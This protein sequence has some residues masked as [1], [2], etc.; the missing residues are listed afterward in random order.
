MEL[1]EPK[2]KRISKIVLDLNRVIMEQNM[3]KQPL[4]KKLAV[5][6]TVDDYINIKPYKKYF[7]KYSCNGC[8]VDSQLLKLSG[9]KNSFHCR[10]CKHFCNRLYVA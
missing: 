10:Y 1:I 3:N 2:Y 4:D 8:I 7:N 9:Y 6:R 5:L